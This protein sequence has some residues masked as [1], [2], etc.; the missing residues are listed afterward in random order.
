MTGTY[1]TILPGGVGQSITHRRIV[2]VNITEREW[3]CSISTPVAV[4]HTHDNPRSARHEKSGK[5]ISSGKDVRREVMRAKGKVAR[6]H[7]AK[8]KHKTGEQHIDLLNAT[9][10]VYPS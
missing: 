1:A 7:K 4:P 6:K 10:Y 9:F 2:S 5:H 8:R 3:S